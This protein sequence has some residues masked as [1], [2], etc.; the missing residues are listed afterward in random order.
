[1]S[2]I[3]SGGYVY[4]CAFNMDEH[5]KFDIWNKGITRRDD[6]AKAAMQGIM[7]NEKALTVL[8][9][10]SEKEGEPTG[11]YLSKWAYKIADDMI[12]QG[13]KE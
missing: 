10:E 3:D 1:M 7:S 9:N 13:R 2:E 5:K 8:N 12:A 6:L 4:P 11:Y